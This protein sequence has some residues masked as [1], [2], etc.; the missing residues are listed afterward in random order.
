ME[1]Y[2]KKSLQLIK[3]QNVETEKEYNKLVHLHKILSLQSLKYITQKNFKE[4]VDLSK[5]V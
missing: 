4:I 5:K 2:Y 3:E 1:Y